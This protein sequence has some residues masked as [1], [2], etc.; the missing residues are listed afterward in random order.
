MSDGIADLRKEFDSLV[1]EPKAFFEEAACG[2]SRYIC[3]ASWY[4]LSDEQRSRANAIGHRNRCL[5]ARLAT[6]I[7][8]SPLLDKQDFRK[9]LRLGRTMDVAL[10]FQAFRMVGI[11]DPDDPP[12]AS[13]VFDDAGDE[14]A[15][16]LDLVPERNTVDELAA[17]GE[18]PPA[19]L[20]R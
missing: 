13:G 3:E 17:T 14:I 15:E 20:A 10:H 5:L 2:R 6:P 4:N 16:L 19:P 1:S 7:Q 8:G 9:F 18:T 11:Y 12:T